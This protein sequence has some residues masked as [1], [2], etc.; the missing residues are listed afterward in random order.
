MTNPSPVSRKP[1]EFGFGDLFD[2]VGEAVI[3]ADAETG[4]IQLWNEAA[5]RMFGYE[6]STAG[7]MP[8]S[9]LVPD[10]LRQS[11]LAG[12]A[13]FAVDGTI[14]LMPPGSTV[15]VPAVRADGSQIW[16]ELSLTSL[17]GEHDRMALALI[18]DVTDRR[19]AQDELARANQALRDFVAEAAHDLRSPAAVTASGI[20][21][22]NE[23]L[24]G[25][26]VPDEASE[27]LELVQRQARSLVSLIAD[28][29]DTASLDAGTVQVRPEMVALAE[30][31]AVIGVHYDDL[32]IATPAGCSVFADPRHLQR[33]LTNL[34]V[35][36]YAH[37]AAPVTI[38][39]AVA[40]P[41]VEIAVGDAGPGVAIELRPRLFDPYV[42]GAK[43]RGTGLGLSIARGLAQANGGDLTYEADLGA[44]HG[45]VL[46]LPARAHE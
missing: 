46:R 33:I 23:L 42:A 31:I 11:H 40:G 37:G 9:V 43:S 22:L 5:S 30:V 32:A 39:A 16:V 12:I 1:Q 26:P 29:L 8:V 3:V 19:N 15:E 24:Q 7:G 28:L 20:E 44:T 4:L 38:T 17:R 18:R 36:A 21:L 35:N 13:R 10:D 45:F 14:R 41:S 27:L 25:V 34:V 6:R 2:L